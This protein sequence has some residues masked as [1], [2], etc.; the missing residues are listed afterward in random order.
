MEEL[1]KTGGKV[2]YLICTLRLEGGKTVATYPKK[3]TNQTKKRK[4]NT[5]KKAT[6]QAVKKSKANK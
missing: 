3:K 4:E 2:C 5:A 1:G 6:A